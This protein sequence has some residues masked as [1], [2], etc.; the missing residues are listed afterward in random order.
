MALYERYNIGDD[1]YR[2]GITNYRLAQT[3]TI[4]N[5]SADEAH[6]ITS[7]KVEVSRY[8]TPGTPGITN[9]EI[10]AV[11]GSNKPTG[12]VLSSG[13]FD[14][15]TLPVYSTTEWRETTM[16]AYTLQPSTMYALILWGPN[17]VTTTDRLLW[18]QDASSPTYTGGQ[19]NQ[20]TD[21]GSTWTQ[22]A[23][24]FMFEIYGTAVVNVTV[25]PSALTLST[26]AQTPTIL[27]IFIQREPL[28]IEIAHPTSWV[29][30]KG[31]YQVV[32][33]TGGARTAAISKRYP[34]TSGLTAGTTKT[35][36]RIMNLVPTE[37]SNVS[38]RYKKGL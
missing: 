23:N 20:S 12:S 19:V 7:V 1:D 16:S 36:G 26:T 24:D 35:E 28:D 2:D 17:W 21:G 15:D 37:G 5:T 13:T 32:G 10:K 8:G 11:D 18:S 22:F 14:A 25:T 38:R 34:V 9:V 30:T 6:I 4:G 29:F 31:T 33:G 3:F 27:A